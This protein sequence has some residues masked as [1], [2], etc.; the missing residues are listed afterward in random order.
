[1][2]RRPASTGSPA[3]PP[4]TTTSPST[5]RATAPR[6]S[7]SSS[8]PPA[9]S[10]SSTGAENYTLTWS[11]SDPE[12]NETW[13][14][15]YANK[16]P[17][18][19]NEVLLP[20]SINT[21]GS[22]GSYVIN[23]AYLDVDTY[24]FFAQ[25]SDGGSTTGAWSEGTITFTPFCVADL[26]NNGSLNLDDVNIFSIS[27]GSGNLTADLD[28]NGVLNLDDVNTFALAFVAGCP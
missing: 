20:T 13:V 17:L 24:W 5:P 25:V 1:M 12:N 9:T 16:T 8:R 2:V 23:S 18:D 19:G 28:G 26:D 14:T 22:L 15:I 7:P 27:F 11:A 4:P 3:P 21:A 6:P 10:S